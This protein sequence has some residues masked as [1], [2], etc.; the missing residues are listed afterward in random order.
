MGQ[1]KYRRKNSQPVKR[2]FGSGHPGFSRECRL[3]QSR[4]AFSI[5]NGR[6]VPRWVSSLII[7]F[8]CFQVILKLWAMKISMESVPSRFKFGATIFNWFILSLSINCRI[9]VVWEIPNI[10]VSGNYLRSLMHP[11]GLL[12]VSWAFTWKCYQIRGLGP[13]HFIPI[14]RY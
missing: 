4:L 5:P 14:Y 7:K 6:H 11:D 13:D 12:I 1:G 8:R 3:L 2:T 10:Y 9:S